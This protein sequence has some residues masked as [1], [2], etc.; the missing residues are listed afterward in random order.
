MKDRMLC[1]TNGQKCG[2]DIA[3]NSN[4]YYSFA[5]MRPYLGPTVRIKQMRLYPESTYSPGHIEEMESIAYL[6]REGD[7]T[8][9]KD[10]CAER[11]IVAEDF[12]LILNSPMILQ[13]RELYTAN[14]QFS[15]KDYKVLYSVKVIIIFYDEQENIDFNY[16]PQFLE[17][18]GVKPI[19]VFRW[20]E[21]E[22]V[23]DVLG[24]LSKAFSSAVSPN[25]FKIVFAEIEDES[26]E[27][28]DEPLTEFRKTNNTSGEILEL[29]K[30]VPLECQ[31]QWFTEEN[32]F[33]LERSSI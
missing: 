2:I 3:R 5:E 7:I 18:P 16:W 1:V 6:W 4:V 12:Q 15:F 26:D 20:L 17:Q 22:S 19:V 10:T 13:C 31:S 28:I 11:I 33:T 8:I 24:H 32:C 23:D 14:A 29:K 9:F 25:A 21:P 30:G 27:E